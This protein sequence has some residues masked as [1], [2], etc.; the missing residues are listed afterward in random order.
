[1]PYVGQ[2]RELY[3]D[4]LLTEPRELQPPDD[5][6][7]AARFAGEVALG[8]FQLAEELEVM[9]N[10]VDDAGRLE[11]WADALIRVA[12]A[13]IDTEE[14]L[15]YL[16]SSISPEGMVDKRW[17]DR[18]IGLEEAGVDVEEVLSHGGPFTDAYSARRSRHASGRHAR[19]HRVYS[20]IS[21]G[22]ELKARAM[23]GVARERELEIR[24]PAAPA[25]PDEQALAETW[26]REI[27]SRVEKG[28]LTPEEAA[29]LLERGL[30]GESDDTGAGS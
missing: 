10:P 25:E 19:H 12:E 23:P 9:V 7:D 1:L 14:I 22:G 5:E 30:P 29:D 6:A 17:A 16:R 4:E 28:E 21:S 15:E 3:G 18:L 24:G 27:I 8:A 20:V 2:V 26:K 11:D 13:G